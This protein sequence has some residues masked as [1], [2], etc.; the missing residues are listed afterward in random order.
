MNEQ[1]ILK[2]AFDKI[3]YFFIQLHHIDDIIHCCYQAPIILHM[4][5]SQTCIANEDVQE[6]AERL[7]TLLKLALSFSLKLDHSIIHNIGYQW[8]Q[9]MNDKNSN[10]LYEQEN[11][12][13]NWIGT[14]YLLWST[15]DASPQQFGTWLY[16]D[17]KNNIIFEITPIYPDT[18]V[19]QEN[20]QEIKAYQEWMA[21][22]YTPFF[23]H[24]ISTD[25]AMQWLHQAN[26]ILQ[27]IK[28]NQI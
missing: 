16:N 20:P 10:L 3:D 21:K 2:F 9:D 5:N 14:K 17:S 13:K 1:N 11:N 19:N 22:E 28:S 8:N 18:F 12:I 25:I 15:S 7:A 27:I 24:I 4:K 23:T 6:Y 26:I